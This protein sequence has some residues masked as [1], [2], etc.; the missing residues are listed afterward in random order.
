MEM[1]GQNQVMLNV[2]IKADSRDA[3]T[4]LCHFGKFQKV[5]RTEMEGQI[6]VM[7]NVD[8][9]TDSRDAN[10]GLCHFD[11]F[12]IQVRWKVRFR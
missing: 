7:L 3:K 10:S 8:I 11:F 4:G 9:K 5:M 12:Q 6:Q 1:E 2:D